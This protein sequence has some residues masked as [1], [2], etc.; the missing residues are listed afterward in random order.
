M[1]KMTK[2]ARGLHNDRRG[3]I[4]QVLLLIGLIAI[5]IALFLTSMGAD[6]RENTKDNAQELIDAQD[7]L[8]DY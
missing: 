4:P 6:V 5:P 7:D 8:K 3:D 2:F 1:L